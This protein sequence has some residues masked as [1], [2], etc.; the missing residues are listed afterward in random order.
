MFIKLKR[1]QNTEYKIDFLN[2]FNKSKT[3]LFVRNKYTVLDDVVAP[4]TAFSVELQ[5]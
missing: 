3:V 4:R 2:K 1:S 5:K